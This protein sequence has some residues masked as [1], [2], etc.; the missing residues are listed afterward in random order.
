MTE[1]LLPTS[2]AEGPGAATDTSPG[3]DDFGRLVHGEVVRV[4]VPRDADEVARLVRDAVAQKASISPRGLSASQGGQ[5][6]GRGGWSFD[7]SGLRWLGEP[8]SGAI[9]CGPGTRWR[10]VVAAVAPLGLIPP[11]LPLNLDLTVGGTL[12][13]GGIG[14]SS[15]R[16]GLAAANVLELEVVSGSGERFSCSAERR[17]DEFRAVLGGLGAFGLVTRAT[18][19]LRPA[20][21]R[22]RSEVLLYDDLDRWLA[23]QRA[24]VASGR[25]DYIEGFCSSA[26]QVL[27][28]TPRG[29]RPVAEW[30]YGLSLGFEVDLAGSPELDDV[31][32]G[33]GP[34]RR[35]HG[36][37]LELMDYARRYDPRFQ[38]M[39]RS[40][41]WKLAHPWFD[42]LVPA[43]RV[44]DTLPRLLDRVPLHLGDG[45]RLF[46]V[47]RPDALS[48]FAAPPGEHV[49]CFAVLPA[50]VAEPLLPETLE[51][52]EE[53]GEEVFRAGGCRYPTGWLGREPA[54][55]WRKQHGER[56]GAWLDARR[57]A[58]P[59]A[60][61]CSAALPSWREL[62]A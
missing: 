39:R 10:D 32:A 55:L 42:C 9:A 61:F 56:Y 20:R 22:V 58:D 7:L 47:K 51:A 60:L 62:Q 17:G 37:T 28:D 26:M 25:C 53:L 2:A 43:Q 27:R 18:L 40:G 12:S 41:G 23:D 38:F 57:H 30:F 44:R 21:P 35:V 29:R 3:R 4:V 36:E 49:A 31:L 14:A 13:V 6:A 54:D 5:S 46:F 8:E 52:L 16:Y 48:Y 11:A 15:H 24:L 50:G 45:H 33:L 59:A 1:P 34:Y 19:A